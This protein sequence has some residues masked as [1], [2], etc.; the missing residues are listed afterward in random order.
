MDQA[1]ILRS[2]YQHSS[3][4]QTQSQRNQADYVFPND[5]LVNCYTLEDQRPKKM[6][7]TVVIHKTG[8]GQ[9]Y[10]GWNEEHQ[11]TVLLGLLPLQSRMR[12]KVLVSSYSW[13]ERGSLGISQSF[14]HWE[15]AGSLLCS[16]LFCDGCQQASSQSRNT[17]KNTKASYLLQHFGYINILAPLRNLLQ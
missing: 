13:F 6:I 12:R 3:S 2:L 4:R 16:Y 9:Q 5:W 15:F 11:R 8:C 10:H 7:Y 1:N 14:V 17:N